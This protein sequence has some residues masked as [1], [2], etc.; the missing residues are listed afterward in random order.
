ME[1]E[2]WDGLHHLENVMEPA[3]NPFAGRNP[4]QHSE[5]FASPPELR[6]AV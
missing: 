1:M 4:A 2:T 6:A 5:E 3:G